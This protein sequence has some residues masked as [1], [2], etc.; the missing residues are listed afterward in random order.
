MPGLSVP[1]IDATGYAVAV[2]VA[3]G[4]SQ[5]CPFVTGIGSPIVSVP[6]VVAWDSEP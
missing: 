2:V 5:I 4:C 1:C 3:A 6:T